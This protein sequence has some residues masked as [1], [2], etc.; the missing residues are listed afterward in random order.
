MAGEFLQKFRLPIGLALMGIVLIIG[1]VFASGLN[2]AQ[3]K[4]FPKESLIQNQKL[5]S[6]DVS[7]A[8][9]KPGVYQVKDESRIEEAIASAGGFSE[10]ANKE[11]ISKYLNMAQKLS[12]GSKLYIPFT[13]EQGN[14]S[15]NIGVVAGENTGAKININT[16]T[17]AELESLNG[18]GSVRASAIIS[19][20]PY[21]TIEDLLNQKI[22][23]KSVFENI[24]DQIVVY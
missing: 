20:R 2:K 12:D 1:G 17:Q 5:I 10:N 8:V 16:A 22:L 23:G 3:P 24:K 6:V 19:G 9:N 15:Q 14:A 13:E 21:Q 4:V 18:I 7:G 11:Y